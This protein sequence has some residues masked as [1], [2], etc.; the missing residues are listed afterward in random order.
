[1][2]P[3][4]CIVYTV[5]VKAP[6][7]CA[8]YIDQELT[9]WNSA[10]LPPCVKMQIHAFALGGC[11]GGGL[12][13]FA[14][15]ICF[16]RLGV[17]DVTTRSSAPCGDSSILGIIFVLSFQQVLHQDR[18]F[19]FRK[20]KIK[21]RPFSSSVGI[22]GTFSQAHSCYFSHQSLLAILQARVH[23]APYS[24]YMS[25][26]GVEHAWI[27]LWHICLHRSE[28]LDSRVPAWTSKKK[29]RKADRGKKIQSDKR[30]KYQES[31]TAVTE[32]K[33]QK[34]SDWRRRRRGIISDE[35]GSKRCAIS[36]SPRYVKC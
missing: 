24:M 32:R 1:M 23:F 31:S 8:L 10:V 11:R 34:Q 35:S 17:Q 14:D 25:S 3:L 28:P 21:S 26:T 2:A 18:S 5:V 30:R 6:L 27:A 33:E 29:K 36:T 22:H 19:F 20:T 15:G 16:F 12:I 7:V 4:H 13:C 9:N